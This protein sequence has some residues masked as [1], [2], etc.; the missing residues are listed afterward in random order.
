MNDLSAET[1][2]F[3]EEKNLSL[4]GSQTTTSRL[5]ACYLRVWAFSPGVKRSTSEAGHPHPH[6]V[7]LKIFGNVLLPSIR[8]KACIVKHRLSFLL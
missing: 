1:A 8:F 7:H 5:Q 3:F 2:R 6:S 4:A